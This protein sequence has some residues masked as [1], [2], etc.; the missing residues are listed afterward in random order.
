MSKCKAPTEVYSRVVGFFRPIQQ[1][2]KGKQEEFRQ[3][4]EYKVDDKQP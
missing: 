3:R 4:K 2:N 1:W